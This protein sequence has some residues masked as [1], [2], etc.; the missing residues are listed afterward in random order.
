MIR[1]NAAGKV[2]PV[3]QAGRSKL[4]RRYE[5]MM[6]CANT[7]LREPYRSRPHMVPLK[8]HWKK[9]LRSLHIQIQSAS[10]SVL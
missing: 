1:T 4:M 5:R 3:V 9:E 6:K 8:R 7:T 2:V 10:L